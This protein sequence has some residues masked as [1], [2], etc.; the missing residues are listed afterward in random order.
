MPLWHND[1]EKGLLMHWMKF[2]S[3]T[4][5]TLKYFTCTFCQHYLRINYIR[6]I[7]F[8]K[9]VGLTR[10]V[11]WHKLAYIDFV[12]T[13]E[14]LCVI[15]QVEQNTRLSFD[16]LFNSHRTLQSFLHR[17]RTTYYCNNY[18]PTIRTIKVTIMITLRLRG[19][20]L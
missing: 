17:L 4:M 20:F 19:A 14:G 11:M 12:V 6:I 8:L 18:N 2:N 5:H 13:L 10:N 9:A 16:G 7:H 3:I 1:A 15:H